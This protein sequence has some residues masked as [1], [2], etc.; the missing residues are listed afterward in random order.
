MDAT[1]TGV[2]TRWT[3]HP[4]VVRDCSAMWMSSV[5]WWCAPWGMPTIRDWCL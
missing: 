1:L 2:N 5:G 4:C 3:R